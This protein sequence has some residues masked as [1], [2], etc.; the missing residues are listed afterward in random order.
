MASFV[1]DL[2][3]DPSF[4]PEGA[5]CDGP[6]PCLNDFSK[7]MNFRAKPYKKRSCNEAIYEVCSEYVRAWFK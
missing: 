3:V 2:T 1:P 4:P 7:A 6:R 5:L